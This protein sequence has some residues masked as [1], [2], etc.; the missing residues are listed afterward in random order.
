MRDAL[1]RTA[2]AKRTVGQRQSAA[3]HDA[4]KESRPLLTLTALRALD[5]RIDDPRVSTDQLL[6]IP[7]E[8][9][10]YI[11]A[12]RGEI[13]VDFDVAMRAEEAANA[14]LNPAQWCGDSPRTLGWH[15][16]LDERLVAQRRATDD[17]LLANHAEIAKQLAPAPSRHSRAS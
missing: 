6:N 10:V 9:E 12:R 17:L 8:L 4:L 3:L 1:R 15:Y 7:L 13:A 14:A 11:R 5:E 2:P 16:A